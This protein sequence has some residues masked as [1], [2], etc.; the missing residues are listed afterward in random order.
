MKIISLFVL[1][2]FFSCSTT[3]F[4]SRTWKD[5]NTGQQMVSDTILYIQPK[6]LLTFWAIEKEVKYKLKWGNLIVGAVFAPTYII[7][8]VLWGFLLFEADK[9]DGDKFEYV[10]VKPETL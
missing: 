4:F 5:E 2:S 10:K 7:P 1:L 6:G 3:Q 8:A 9:I